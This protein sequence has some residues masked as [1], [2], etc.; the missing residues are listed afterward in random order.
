[1]LSGVP[2]DFDT[3]S[4]AR[5]CDPHDEACDLDQRARV[6][7]DVNYAMCQRPNGPGNA[8]ID[9]RFATSLESTKMI[10]E[11]PA[12]GDLGIAD[13]R[14]IKPGDADSSLLL[15]R[16]DT[17][18]NGRMPNIGSNVIDEKAVKLLREWIDSME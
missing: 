12:Q 6:L 14:I 17:I 16:M 9:L 10:N 2:E 8:S 3:E 18:S 13:A 5:H 7:L 4:A 1:L 15:R 11:K